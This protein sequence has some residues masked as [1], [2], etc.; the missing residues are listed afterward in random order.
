[1]FSI[2]PKK[3]VSVSDI[4]QYLVDEYKNNEKK[5][6]E[7][8][9]LQD[10]LKDKVKIQIKYETALVTLDEYKKRLED[11]D[12]RINTLNKQIKSLNKEIKQEIDFKNTKILEYKKLEKMY[13]DL[14]S[15]FNDRL[16]KE[17]KLKQKDYVEEKVNQLNSI[18]GHLKKEDIIKLLRK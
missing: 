1:M 3:K 4:K 15:D 5:Q 13:N 2:I 7:I 16:K 11:R 14:K 10:E 12:S 8:Y 18:K 9:R 17:L 6:K